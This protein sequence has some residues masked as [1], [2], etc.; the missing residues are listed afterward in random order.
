METT[1]TPLESRKRSREAP[2]GI[3]WTERDCSDRDTIHAGDT[4]IYLLH[5]EQGS[6]LTVNPREEQKIGSKKYSV[7]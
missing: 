6:M 3:A 7:K 5:D 2:G 4:V 1:N